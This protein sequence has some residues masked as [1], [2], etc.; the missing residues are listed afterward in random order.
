M[1]EELPPGAL[2]AARQQRAERAP[3]SSQNATLETQASGTGRASGPGLREEDSLLSAF[4]EGAAVSVDDL[5]ESTGLAIP[6]LLGRLAG[7]E[8]SGHVQRL[9]GGWFMR[10]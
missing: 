2:A 8:A 1:L 3:V 7:L 5:A 9:P 6:G 4:P 10:A